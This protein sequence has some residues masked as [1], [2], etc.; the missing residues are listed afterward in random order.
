MAGRRVESQPTGTSQ[1]YDLTHC[2]PGQAAPSTRSLNQAGRRA[3]SWT[4]PVTQCHT[5]DRHHLEAALS[6]QLR[7]GHAGVRRA[8]CMRVRLAPVA[9]SVIRVG[10]Y[11]LWTSA[12]TIV[13]GG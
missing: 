4:V 1:R 12:F 3:F 7:S 6:I 10:G 13:T 8:I 9:E 11:N 2:H 5:G